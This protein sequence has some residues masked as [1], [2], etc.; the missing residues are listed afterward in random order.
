LLREGRPVHE[1]VM[2]L[3]GIYQGD[4][5]RLLARARDDLSAA[6]TAA[7]RDPNA[8]NVQR[9][10][11]DVANFHDRYH[12]DLVG[13]QEAASWLGFQVEDDAAGATLLA[14]L[15]PPLPRD[16]FAISPEDPRIGALKLG[17]SLNRYD[18][19]RIYLDLAARTIET[20]NQGGDD[21]QIPVDGATDNH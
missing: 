17:M 4:F 12:Y 8:Q 21:G 14:Q 3:A 9:M 16:A 2:K 5:D 13:P 6:V 7:T 1:T 19:E 15:L 11:S 18:F 10:W 20:L